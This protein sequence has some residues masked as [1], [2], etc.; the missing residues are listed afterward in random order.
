MCPTLCD[1][2]DFSPSG[3]SFHGILPGRILEWVAISSSRGSFWPRDQ[4]SVSCISCVGRLVLY[5]QHHLGSPESIGKEIIFYK[6]TETTEIP[7]IR[8]DVQYFVSWLLLFDHM[9]EY[10]HAL[11][12][13]LSHMCMHTHTHSFTNEGSAM[14]TIFH[15][16]DIGS[17]TEQRTCGFNPT[18]CPQKEA[19]SVPQNTRITWRKKKQTGF[20]AKSLC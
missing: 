10:S 1:P 6:N 20:S 11:S 12:L 17:H 15:N 16:Q 14:H 19:V 8:E 3:S 9:C 13:S 7:L 18:S 2:M 4:T 5:H